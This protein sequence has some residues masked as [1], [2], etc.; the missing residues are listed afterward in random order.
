[1]EDN[2]NPVVKDQETN[3]P[4]SQWD[5]Y[6]T[7]AATEPDHKRH[8]GPKTTHQKNMKRKRAARRT[9]KASRKNNR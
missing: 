7:A 9:Q 6:N 1:M 5:W 4:K 3:D 8:G 2:S